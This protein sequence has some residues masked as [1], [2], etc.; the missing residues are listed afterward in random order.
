MYNKSSNCS[1]KSHLN[2][3]QDLIE[4]YFK[5]NKVDIAN[6]IL[7][8]LFVH[9]QRLWNTNVLIVAINHVI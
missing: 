6:V 5:V 1:T 7:L 3:L 9:R 8:M 4:D 2:S